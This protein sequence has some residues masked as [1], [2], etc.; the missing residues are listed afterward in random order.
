MEQLWIQFYAMSKPDLQKNVNASMK[1]AEERG[2][3]VTGL[4]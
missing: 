3:L 2:K 4:R 1:T